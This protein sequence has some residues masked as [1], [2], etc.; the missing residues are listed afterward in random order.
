MFWIEWLRLAGGWGGKR[1]RPEIK[2]FSCF[3]NKTFSDV[4]RETPKNPSLNRVKNLNLL[5]CFVLFRI[6]ESEA[7]VGSIDLHLKWSRF[8]S[9]VSISKQK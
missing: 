9:R 3:P 4:V 2:L 5:F 8:Y 7:L 6:T 1:P